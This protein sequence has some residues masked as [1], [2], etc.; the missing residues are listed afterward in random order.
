VRNPY[1]NV[2]PDLIRDK[3]APRVLAEGPAYLARERLELVSDWT[4]E[5]HVVAPEEVNWAEVAAGVEPLRVRQ[6]PGRDNMMGNVKFMLPNRLGI[7][8]HDTPNKAPFARSDR[9]LSSGCVRLEDAEALSRWL[10]G[11]KGEPPIEGAESRVDLPQPVPVYITYLTVV[12]APG[13][14]IALQRDV[15][16]RDEALMA[17]LATSDGHGKKA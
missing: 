13:G 10:R 3:I 1:W 4:P 14:G 5:A 9:R 2:P 15:Y 11:A 16:G 12:P 7:Y 17:R 6:L 8:L